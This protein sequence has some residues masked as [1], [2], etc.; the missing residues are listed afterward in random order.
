MGL[1][2]L[3]FLALS[4]TRNGR[5]SESQSPLEGVTVVSGRRLG[6]TGSKRSLTGGDEQSL[7]VPLV[8]E[9]E[10]SLGPTY[11]PLTTPGFVLPSPYHSRSLGPL[12]TRSE[13]HHWYPCHFYDRFR[14]GHE[15]SNPFFTCFV[16]PT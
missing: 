1:C 2:T 12:S 10:G 4:K 9:T 11:R 5:N 15:D 7:V 13:D 6:L 16:N 14:G 3:S 8:A